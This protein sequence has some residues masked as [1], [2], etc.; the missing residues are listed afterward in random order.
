LLRPA[1]WPCPASGD[2]LAL[3]ADHSRSRRILILP[4][5]FDEANRTRHFTVEVMR[6]LHEMGMDCFLPD[7]AGCNE[8]SHLLTEQTIARWREQASSAAEHFGATHIVAIRAGAMLA[9]PAISTIFYAPTTAASVLRGLLRARIIADKEAG[10]SVSREDLLTEG[11]QRGL[12]LA[13]YRL[14]PQMIAEMEAG[15]LEEG[16]HAA[17]AQADIGGSGL[18]LRAE[19]EHDPKQAHNLAQAIARLVS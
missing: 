5:W 10:L 19:P 11:K 15:T 4:A 17:I 13:G 12:Q 1:T 16:E 18:W 7:F 14:G 9:P 2:E 8:S 3:I 6:L